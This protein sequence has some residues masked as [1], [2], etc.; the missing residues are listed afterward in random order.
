MVPHPY[1]HRRQALQILITHSLH[2]E[3]HLTLGI[4]EEEL[5]L[6]VEIIDSFAG[7]LQVLKQYELQ[8]PMVAV[9]TQHPE[10]FLFPCHVLDRHH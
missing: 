8:L 2:L 1:P 10:T 4:T 7:L 9:H 3:E 5:L 6:Q